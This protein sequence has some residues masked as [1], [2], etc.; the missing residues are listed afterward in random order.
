[1][2]L[3]P[4]L[5]TVMP[6]RNWVGNCQKAVKGLPVR[7]AALH[8]CLANTLAFRML[9]AQIGLA[10]PAFVR[11]RFQFHLGTSDDCER[12]RL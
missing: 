3:W 8:V 7:A 12:G 6:D 5:N 4:S 9:K 10:V 11:R 2:I 1:V